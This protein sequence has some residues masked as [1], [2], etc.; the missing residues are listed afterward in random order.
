MKPFQCETV[1]EKKKIILKHTTNFKYSTMYV[2][3]PICIV[4]YVLAYTA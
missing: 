3:N 4:P 1:K 2:E